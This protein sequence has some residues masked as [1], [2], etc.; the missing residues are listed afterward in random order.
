LEVG[1]KPKRTAKTLLEVQNLS[2]KGDRG[3]VAVKNA[4]FSI[5]AGEI[6]AILGVAGNGQRE[7]VEALVGLRPMATGTIL[8][9][10]NPIFEQ[11]DRV[12][13]IPEDRTERASI[14]DMSLAENVALTRRSQFSQGQLFDWQ[15]VK[16]DTER[17]ISKYNITAPSLDMKAGQLSGG[18]LQKLILARAFSQAPLLLLA[19]QPTRGLDIGATEE[20]WQALLAHRETGGVL[21]VSGDL[22]EVLS[23]SDRILVLFRGTVMDIIPCEDERLI[24]RVGPL[25]AGLKGRA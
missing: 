3:E 13:Y 23:L 22:K 19:E 1:K 7:L 4:S 10:G 6:F 2:V 21:L 5:K 11:L 16:A 17:L 12:A 24:E 18:N 15:G 14:P 9:E 8:L 25:M 20:I